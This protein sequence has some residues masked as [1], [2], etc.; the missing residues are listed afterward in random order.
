MSTLDLDAP[1]A[2][3]DALFGDSHF[4]PSEGRPEAF[5]GT[6]KRIPGASRSN[7]FYDELTFAGGRERRTP[8]FLPLYLG[9]DVIEAARGDR[10]GDVPTERIAAGSDGNAASGPW[11]ALTVA[12]GSGLAASL[13][14][15]PLLRYPGVAI[16]RVFSPLGGGTS[17]LRRILTAA[18]NLALS[19][20]AS[21]ALRHPKAGRIPESGAVRI[22]VPYPVFGITDRE[23]A[24][25]NWL[26]ANLNIPYLYEVVLQEEAAA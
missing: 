14:V 12:D 5:E 2:F 15:S 16:L 11:G 17:L 18:S 3:F 20:R 6:A 21:Q 26:Q 4:A 9:N 25:R 23:N 24:D 8:R 1:R 19:H 10:E 22:G 7:I 13:G